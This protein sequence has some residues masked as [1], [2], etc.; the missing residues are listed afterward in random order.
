MHKQSHPRSAL[1]SYVRI[2]R[3]IDAFKGHS[4]F[5]PHIGS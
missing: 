1:T 4:D 2:Y 3:S 5:Y